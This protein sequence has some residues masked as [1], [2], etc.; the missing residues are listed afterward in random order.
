M[1]M[2]SEWNGGWRSEREAR[3]GPRFREWAPERGAPGKELRTGRGFAENA[4][5]SGSPAV[6]HEERDK[7]FA[8]G[9]VPLEDGNN[10]KKQA[11]TKQ[12]PNKSQK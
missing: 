2:Q 10:R 11:R 6:K 4:Q 1:H 5:E 12:K 9:C 8:T 7:I 3:T